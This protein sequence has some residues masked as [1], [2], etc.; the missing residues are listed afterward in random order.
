MLGAVFWKAGPGAVRR[1]FGRMF[2]RGSSRISFLMS[3]RGKQNRRN[4]R[5][6]P[7]R[8]KMYRVRWMTW[9]KV[10]A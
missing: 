7:G 5:M 4:A 3:R 6:S 9:K 1:T 2:H 8:M 10:Y